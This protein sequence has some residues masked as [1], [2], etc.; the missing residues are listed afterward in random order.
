[1]GSNSKLFLLLGLGGSTLVLDL[2]SKAVVSRNLFLG[3]SFDVIDGMLRITYIQNK[4]AIFGLS[5][6]DITGTVVLVVSLLA[7]VLLSIYYF[8]SPLDLKWYGVGLV[9]ILSG[10]AGNLYD[11]VT[12][13]GVR[14][15]LD[16]GFGT[17]RWPVFNVADLAVTAGA[18]LL[19]IELSRRNDTV[20][21]N[22]TS[23]E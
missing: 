13:G 14:D 16:I 20:E 17:T 6:G 5:I 10:A 8:T 18:V 23:V 7:V 1:M 12:L 22:G 19:V 9:L 21:K 3:Q 15:F 11:R 2:W 4:G